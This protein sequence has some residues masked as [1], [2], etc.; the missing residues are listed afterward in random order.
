MTRVRRARGIA[1]ILATLVAATL[2][3]TAQN[4]AHAATGS[5]GAAAQKP[6]KT[7]LHIHVTGCDRCSLQLQHAVNGK[8]TV[9]S[10]AWQRIG[11]D[12]VAHFKVRT[13]RT[14]GLSFAIRAPWQG[15]TGAVSNV[16]T[17]YAGQRVDAGVSRA[18]ARH[19]GRAEG[20]WAGTASPV[21]PLHF[22]VGRVPAQT[23]DGQ[24]T[25]LPLAYA[26][27]TMS[28]WKPMVKTFRGT[29]G[30][31]D[32]FYCTKPPTTKMT[33]QAAGCNG[34]E[35]QLMNG[36]IHGENVWAPDPQTVHSGSVTFR[37]P[38][39]M[40]RGITAT[41]I[42]PW[43]GATG[44][45]TVVAFRY[46]GHQ[47]GDPVSFADARAQHRGSPCW[48]GTSSK[49][50]TLT[51]TTRKVTVPGTTGPTAGTIAYADVTQ[52]WLK[53]MMD[54]G[55]GVLGSQEVIVCRK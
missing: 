6:A 9:W 53:P 51:L 7:R 25:Q 33:L 46:V 37:V 36:A 19:G 16:V 5:G 49:D 39:P 52:S 34:C 54:A 14:Q 55:K 26:R 41:V 1:A 3:T 2:A 40:T 24:D 22:H 45:T 4:D 23:L 32:A 20:C 31:Q 43:E 15:N 38:R 28:S 48:G 17:R 47:A 27:H 10:S 21:M 8:Q 29:I 11:S 50:V 13:T 42:G 12:H 18:E 30:N 35:V 44:Y